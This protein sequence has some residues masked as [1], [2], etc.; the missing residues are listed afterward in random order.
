[1]SR[2]SRVASVVTLWGCAMLCAGACSEASAD[3]PFAFPETLEAAHA[4]VV[5]PTWTFTHQDGVSQSL[6]D[7]AGHLVLVQR[8]ATWCRPCVQELPSVAALVDAFRGQR[9]RVLLLSDESPDVVRRFAEQSGF[10]LPFVHAVTTVPSAFDVGGRLPATFLL[11]ERGRLLH[12]FVGQA[13][14]NAPE[15]HAYLRGLLDLSH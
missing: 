4:P 11:D 2:A 6:G 13:D 12:E 10:R 8:W 14:W 5:D 15:V 1:M 9:L 3:S 7:L